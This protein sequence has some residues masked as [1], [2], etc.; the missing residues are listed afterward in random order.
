[1]EFVYNIV[2]QSGQS[3]ELGECTVLYILDGGRYGEGLQALDTGERTAPDKL[4]P[5]GQCD[6]IE[7]TVSAL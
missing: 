5:F 6:G 1:M 3:G 7:S 4:Q 2:V